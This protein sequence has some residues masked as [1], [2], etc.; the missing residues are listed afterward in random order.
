VDSV[1]GAFAMGSM[2][3]ESTTDPSM[4]PLA[5]GGPTCVLEEGREEDKEFSLFDQHY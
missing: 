4:A 1:I 3:M 2:V 5:R